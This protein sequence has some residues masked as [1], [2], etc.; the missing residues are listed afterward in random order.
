MPIC[1]VDLVSDVLTPLGY[2]LVSSVVELV[3]EEDAEMIADDGAGA[4]FNYGRDKA[5]RRKTDLPARDWFGK[6]VL[7]SD[8][9]G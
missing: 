9:D 8:L 5:P 4:E 7:R 3:P 1:Y 6:A 2:A